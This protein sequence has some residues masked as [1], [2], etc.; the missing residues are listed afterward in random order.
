MQ[1]ISIRHPC[2]SSFLFP[3]I[4][5]K[6]DLVPKTHEPLV[7]MK[8]NGISFFDTFVLQ[9]SKIPED[10]LALGKFILNSSK[11]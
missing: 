7:Q 11:N 10:K 4:V 1:R 9:G 5:N 6:S 8:V 3:C 2:I